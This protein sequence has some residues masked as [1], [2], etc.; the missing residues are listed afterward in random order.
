MK[1]LGK[2]LYSFTDYAMM[3]GMTRKEV[4]SKLINGNLDLEDEATLVSKEEFTD[5]VG[6]IAKT[7][8][9]DLLGLH[10]GQHL[11]FNTLGVIHKISIKSLTIQEGIFYCQSFLRKTFPY[12]VFKNKGQ[13]NKFM[14]TINLPSFAKPV[15]R[16]VLETT[17]TVVT[18]E[19]KLMW[20]KENDIK[21]FSPFVDNRYPSGWGLS[22]NYRVECK[23][24]ILKSRIKDYSDSGLDILIPQYLKTM[25]LMKVDKGLRTKIKVA[26]L[27]L[28]LPHLPPIENVASQFN[29]NVRTL[30]RMLWREGITFREILD[31]LK[32]ELSD[33]L[34]RHA[35]F[36]ITDIASMLGYSEPAAFIR[37]FKKWHG[38]PPLK[39]RKPYM[40]AR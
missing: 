2:H 36:S 31:E 19:L 38:V 7:L 9:E 37:T 27:S 32:M 26:A 13:G 4:S 24:N 25:E 1:I 10:V 29:C 34:I 12:I 11:D 21:T 20:G 5:T 35:R 18:R 39:F 16:I 30:Q 6:S 23:I 15:S 14:I 28:A 17:L 8:K 22:G 3:R 33:M 40:L